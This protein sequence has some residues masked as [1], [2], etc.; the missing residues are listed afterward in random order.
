MSAAKHTPGPYT[1]EKAVVRGYR[2]GL[3]HI[4]WRVCREGKQTSFF[5]FKAS[6]VEHAKKCND[7]ILKA[8]GEGA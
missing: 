4:G 7:A 8:T 2:G 6:A 3:R 1:V 5:K